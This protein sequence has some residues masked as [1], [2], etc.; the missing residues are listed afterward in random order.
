[1]TGQSPAPFAPD[2]LAGKTALVTGASSGLGAHF[3]KTLGRAGARVG[4]AAR[5][6]DRLEALAHE[7][8]EAGGEAHPV[9]LDVTHADGVS[10]AFD[11]LEAA[12][13]P[14]TIVVNNAGI[15]SSS[16]F[17]DMPE[18]EWRGVLD[19]NLDGVFRVGQEAARRMKA[20]AQGGSIINISSVLGLMV[21]NRLSAYAVSKA[22]VIQLTKAM[23]LEL[24]RD[25]IRVNALAPGYIHTEMNDDFLHSDAGQKLLSKVPMARAG[26]THE[27]DGPLLLLASDLGSYMTGSVI[28]VDGGSLLALR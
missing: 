12:L 26:N 2:L 17:A 19:V 20:A 11:N 18:D 21:L 9:A 25:G 22:A 3:A 13:G 15:P 23:A 28:A 24:V 8:R 27:L 4:L 1:M 7:I 16:R 5:R 10:A 6:V 14:A